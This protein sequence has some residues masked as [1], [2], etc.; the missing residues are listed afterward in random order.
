[1]KTLFGHPG[2]VAALKGPPVLRFQCPWLSLKALLSRFLRSERFHLTWEHSGVFITVV[3]SLFVFLFFFHVI[4]VGWC[5]WHQR[6]RKLL[7]ELIS[8]SLSPQPYLSVYGQSCLKLPST[9]TTP[10]TVLFALNLWME[11]WRAESFLLLFLSQ[12]E[13]K[14]HCITVFKTVS[15][16]TNTHLA[17]LCGHCMQIPVFC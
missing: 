13:A 12:T 3:A 8:M 2:A 16:Q 15:L 10:T 5:R 1:M 9:P 7:W 17:R 6:S 14:P 11:W 4:R